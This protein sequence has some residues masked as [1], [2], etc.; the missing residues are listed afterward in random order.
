[1]RKKRFKSYD[2]V[3]DIIAG[4]GLILG[5]GIIFI[6][7]IARYIFD[8]PLTFVDEIAPIFIVWSTG[9]CFAVVFLF[10]GK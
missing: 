10:G 1:M 7:I 3:E 8:H 2:K 6:G 5:V 9:R 4:I